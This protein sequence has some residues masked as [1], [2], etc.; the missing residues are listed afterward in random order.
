MLQSAYL[1]AERPLADVRVSDLHAYNAAYLEPNFR[2]TALPAAYIPQ[3]A[4]LLKDHDG[5][6]DLHIHL[7]GAME[8][9]LVWQDFLRQPRKVY[10][11]FKKEFARTEVREQLMQE[12]TSPSPLAFYRMLRIARRL[13]WLIADLV[14]GEPDRPSVTEGAWSALF[15]ESSWESRNGF[16]HPVAERLWPEAGE[17]TDMTSES[18]LYV[19]VFHRLTQQ[20]HGLLASAFHF[21]LLVLGTAN[22]LLVQQVHQYGF[23][24]FQKH[25]LN[26]LR[27]YSEQQYGK[28]FLQM[29]GNDG[30]YV[31]F[32]EGRFS[33]KE[34][35]FETLQLLRAIG[36]GWANML[37]ERERDRRLMPFRV[38]PI[39]PRLN[40]IAHF[41]KRKE[42]KKN[43][44]IRH[45]NLRKSIWKR[46]LV[47]SL[48]VN[49][50]SRWR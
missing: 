21:Y 1:Q 29:Q 10:R 49:A 27:E 44:W 9:D 24:Q 38:A 11:D 42:D 6:H 26:G 25:T 20:P 5:L 37:R 2:A 50:H 3:L 15:Q 18:L 19:L 31:R 13:R 14:F 7:N 28:R 43:P 30:S 45:Y 47:L 12:H 32:I 36:K 34:T 39:P 4:S 17:N 41:I 46:A 33:P 48:L 22:R 8:T 16:R 23:E 40:L 35:Q